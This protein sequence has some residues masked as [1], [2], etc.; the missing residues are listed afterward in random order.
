MNR[1][2]MCLKEYQND[3]YFCASL[4]EIV[5]SP[6]TTYRFDLKQAKKSVFDSNN[7]TCPECHYNVISNHVECGLVLFDSAKFFTILKKSIGL[8]RLRKKNRLNLEQTNVANQR[9]VAASQHY[10]FYTQTDAEYYSMS[11]NAISQNQTQFMN[12]NSIMDALENI[13]YYGFVSF[14]ATIQRIGCLLNIYL[15]WIKQI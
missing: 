10:L 14:K 2:K 7:L 12:D 15:P 4:I 11:R 3:V 13:G 8:E 1:K 9:G 6:E 5:V